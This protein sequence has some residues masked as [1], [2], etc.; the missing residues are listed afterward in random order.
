[1]TL[2]CAAPTAG[3][4]DWYF[5]FTLHPGLVDRQEPRLS[6]RAFWSRAADDGR[7]LLHEKRLSELQRLA[8]RRDLD[9]IDAARWNYEAGEIL[10]KRQ[11]AARRKANSPMRLSPKGNLK[12]TCTSAKT[13]KSRTP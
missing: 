8:L 1:M 3:Q 6:A 4:T 10:M 12:P 11:K 2:G 13:P 7:I 9:R 5:R